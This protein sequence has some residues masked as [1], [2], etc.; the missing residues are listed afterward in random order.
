MK[1]KL[2]HFSFVLAL[3]AVFILAMA[4]A[5][6]MTAANRDASPP[7]LEAKEEIDF[8]RMNPTMKMSYAYRLAANPEE[9]AGKTVRISGQFLTRID[10]EDGKRYFGCLIGDA[11][12]CS[13]CSSAFVLEFTSKA[14]YAWPTNFPPAESMIRLT[15][16]LKMFEVVESGQSY[17]IP[18]L[19]DAEIAA[20]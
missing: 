18:R 9:F 20:L 4:A 12:G 2:A 10:E 19:V 16:T 17:E 3:A 15:G 8:T 6:K 11:A 13:C 5:V 7:P 14:G 1:K